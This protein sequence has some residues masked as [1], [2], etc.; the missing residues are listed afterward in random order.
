MKSFQLLF[1]VFLIQL[2][3][4][5]IHAQYPVTQ[6]I[7]LNDGSQVRGQYE[8]PDVAVFRGIP[9]AQT[10]GGANRWR[11]PQP[12]PPPSQPVTVFDAFESGPACIQSA[13]LS[14]IVG[15]QSEDCLSVDLYIPA[16]QMQLLAS[17]PS[18]VTL[19]PTFVW[20]FGGGYSIG[21]GAVYTGFGFA[22]NASSS[23]IIFVNFNYR[24]SLLGFF[25]LDGMEASNFG[26]LDQVFF[27]QWLQKNLPAFG[28]DPSRVTIGGESAGG[29]STAFHLVMPPSK[30]LFSQAIME[31]PGIWMY[32]TLDEQRNGSQAVAEGFGCSDV[33]CMRGI[34]PYAIVACCPAVTQLASVFLPAIQTDLIPAEPLYAMHQG[35][36]SNPGLS[37][38]VGNQNQE[39]NIMAYIITPGVLN[40]TD[41]SQQQFQ[42][43]VLDGYFQPLGLSSFVVSTYKDLIPSD[44]NANFWPA[45]SQIIG[46]YEVRCGA[47]ALV[48]AYL[49]ST[50]SSAQPVVMW[51]YAFTHHP[52]PLRS[53]TYFL[54]ATHGTELPYVFQS[55][56]TFYFSFTKAEAVFSAQISDYWA[57][58]V[59][60]G[61]PGSPWPQYSSSNS[62]PTTFR[63]DIPFTTGSTM[64]PA[65]QGYCDQWTN[66][67]FSKNNY[68][69]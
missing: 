44:P 55:P 37:V 43:L 56:A 23:P 21:Q 59:A 38:L 5:S 46:D 69:P 26:M 19:S 45:A 18:G 3:L 58:F 16:A 62:D 49:T 54:N 10:T 20:I 17:N 15:G 7:T 40:R 8:R 60:T 48:R 31:S 66:L 57:N 24:V 52:A 11:P 27:L 4:S 63:L 36:W 68:Y 6:V 35:S 64:T 61:K 2:C 12:L 28:G 14:S 25:Y 50:P 41:M 65:Q 47:E 42:E 29:S 1:V 13:N 9:F 34:S 53:P 51:R 30:G 33:D 39:G 22:G 32:P 67:F